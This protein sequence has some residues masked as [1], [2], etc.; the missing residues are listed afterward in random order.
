M[1]KPVKKT[2]GKSSRPKAPR[3]K[4]RL[5]SV[6]AV[7]PPQAVP[8]APAVPPPSVGSE[9][10]FSVLFQNAF[11]ACMKMW[12]FLIIQSLAALLNLAMLGLVLLVGCWPLI[13]AM[14]Q[15]FGDIFQNPDSYDP[16]EFSNKLYSIATSDYSWLGIFLGLL[17]L[18]FVWA[19]FLEALVNGGIYGGFW[20]LKREGKGFSLGDF[21]KDALGRFLPFLGALVLLALLSFAVAV[22]FRAVEIGGGFLLKAFHLGPGATLAAVVF[23]GVPLFLVYLVAAFGVVAYSLAVKAWVGSGKGIGESLTLGWKSCRA[24]S[25]HFT[26]CVLLALIGL[27]ALFIV[28]QIFLLLALLVPLVGF[29]SLFGMLFTGAFFMVF[30]ALYFP[31]LSVAML[32]EG[33]SS[34]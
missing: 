27:A 28:I 34:V 26:K 11:Q 17:L 29:L 4:P 16:Q 12:P 23:F 3:R 10:S 8:E 22:G 21:L 30:F 14:G 15:A 32:D 1:A 5:S 33:G 2:G 25:W 31:A 20:R 13:A 19:L 6:E 18:Y 7:V 24:Q 9:T